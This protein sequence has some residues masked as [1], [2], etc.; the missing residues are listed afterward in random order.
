VDLAGDDGGTR[1]AA[2][3]GED[4]GDESGRILMSYT[5]IN[6]PLLDSSCLGE[7]G[8]RRCGV[9]KVERQTASCARSFTRLTSDQ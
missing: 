5:I 4:K 6:I 8:R 3:V 2:I 7:F 9:G 1:A